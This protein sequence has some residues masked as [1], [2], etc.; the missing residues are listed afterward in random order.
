MTFKPTR[1]ALEQTIRFCGRTMRVTGLLQIETPDGALATRYQLAEEAGAPQILEDSAGLLFHLRALPTGPQTRAVDNTVSVMGQKYT[2]SGVRRFR[3]LGAS[4]QPP[5]GAPQGELL[6]SGLFEGPAGALL[7]ELAPGSQAQR[8][9]SV[10]PLSAADVLSAEQLAK[11]QEGERL[12]ALLQA[13]AAEEDREARRNGPLF[14][15]VAIC[16]A[17]LVILG[18]GYACTA[19]H[20]ATRAPAKKNVLPS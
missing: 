15:A 19:E 9:Y 11:A 20:A 6:V 10:K 13:Q 7:R 12:A 14:R 4:G 2:L 16:V 3:I 1:F 17:G 8:F 18:L 5:G